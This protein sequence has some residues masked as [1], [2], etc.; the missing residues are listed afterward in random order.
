ME[1]VGIQVPD[2]ILFGLMICL[3]IGLF[4]IAWLGC[5]AACFLSGVCLGQTVQLS[6]DGRALVS[7]R[8]YDNKAML[9]YV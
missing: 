5:L 3:V 4:N 9:E 6:K 8:T 1:N 7:S 2:S